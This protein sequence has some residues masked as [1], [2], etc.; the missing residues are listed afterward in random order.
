[1]GPAI[2]SLGSLL[3]M[4]YGCGE[5]NMINFAPAVMVKR[6]LTSVEMLTPAIDRTATRYTQMGKSLQ[7]SRR[8]LLRSLFI[9]YQRQLTYKRNDDSYAVWGQ[10]SSSGSIWY[11]NDSGELC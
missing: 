4:P 1:M 3:K 11:D 6:Y 9:G 2:N 8:C 7:A 10:S 5:Q